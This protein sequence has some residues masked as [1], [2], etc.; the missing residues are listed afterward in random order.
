MS[1]KRDIRVYLFK[2]YVSGLLGIGLAIFI[3]INDVPIT[4]KWLW[5]IFAA[6]AGVIIL[7]NAMPFSKK[8]ERIYSEGKFI[9]MHVLFSRFGIQIFSKKI[10][11]LPSASDEDIIPI[12]EG[13]LAIVP[14]WLKRIPPNGA[15]R[16][17]GAANEDGPVVM[18]SKRG[19]K[20]KLAWTIGYG[21]TRRVFKQEGKAKE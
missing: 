2:Q 10:K 17:Y 7:C 13:Q 18:E 15:V 1:L 14:G 11:L 9:E 20:D 5:I 8:I 6:G 3:Y 12:I 19:E 16:V 21:L 4:Y